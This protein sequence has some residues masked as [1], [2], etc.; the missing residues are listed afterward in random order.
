MTR[1]FSLLRCRLTTVACGRHGITSSRLRFTVASRLSHSFRDATGT[2]MPRASDPSEQ[3]RKRM[4]RLQEKRLSSSG[5]IRANAIYA[6]IPH[7]V[8]DNF[9]AQVQEGG[10]YVISR[11]RVTNAKNYFRVVEGRYMIEFTYHTRVA[12][13]R[14][15]P[16]GFPKYVYSLTPFHELPNLVGSSRNF[17]DILGM[18]T[19][20]NGIEQ[21]QVS[22]NLN[23]IQTRK[24]ILRDASDIEMHMTLWGQRASNF[25]VDELCNSNGGK[26]V[27]VLFVGCLVKTFQG[28]D[29]I[30]AG[31]A[32][33]WHFKPEI[34]EVAE[35]SNKFQNEMIHINHLPP[36]PNNS[37][38]PQGMLRQ[39][40]RYL[41]DLQ[42][43]DPYDFPANGCL[44]TITIARLIADVPWWFPSCTRCAQSYYT[45]FKKYMVNS[46]ITSYGRQRVIPQIPPPAPP[47]QPSHHPSENISDST[48]TSDQPTLTITSKSPSQHQTPPASPT[49]VET[50]TKEASPPQLTNIRSSE[51]I[52]KRLTYDDKSDDEASS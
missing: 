44:C 17:L 6:E 1:G 28:Q 10:I 31:S 43:I 16:T 21:V 5:A 36:P 13:A 33:K 27:P 39:E 22:P 20:V 51:S 26:Q 48:E 23:Q 4:K 14:D 32:S 25:D 2:Y 37:P 8:I 46:I 19:E 12:V 41:A 11:F 38:Q 47:K 24:L 9:D 40:S 18:V 15:P 42:R 30:S 49:G 7:D 52:R 45:R 50:S 3:R 34:P 29:Y 35:F